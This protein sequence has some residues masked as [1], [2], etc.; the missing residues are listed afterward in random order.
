MQVPVVSWRNIHVK[1]VAYK[2]EGGLVG[3]ES[4]RTMQRSQN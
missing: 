2:W 4:S 3:A 1:V